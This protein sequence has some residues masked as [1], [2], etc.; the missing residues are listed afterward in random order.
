MNRK[1]LSWLG[2]LALLGVVVAGVWFFVFRESSLQ[3]VDRIMT[4]AREAM[5]L[6][7]FKKA[8]QLVL[9]AIDILPHSPV[10]QHDLAVVYLRQERL[11]DAKAAFVRA[12]SLHGPDA[13]EPRAIEYFQIADIDVKQG[14]YEDAERALEMAIAA[15]PTRRILHTRLIDLQLGFLEKPARADSSTRRFLRLCKPT[16]QNFFDAARVHYGR[17][18]MLMAAALAKQ[19]AAQADTLIQAHALTGRALW[20]AGRPDSG[21]AYLEGPLDRYPHEAELWVVQGSLYI[22]AERYDD[23]MRSLQRALEIDPDNYEAQRAR[24]MGLFMAERYDESLA[25]AEVCARLT[26]NEDEQR[27][28]RMHVNR[29]REILAGKAPRPGA[30][31]DSETAP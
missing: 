13:N 18:N 3:R 4:E 25:A 27:F 30:P 28:L 6:Y 21:L 24:M 9:D 20:R 11:D 19:A 15:H 22:G 29:V 8:E 7:E 14:R 2:P 10:L 1:V 12:A 16:T 26:D 31:D 17:K 5:G 23:A